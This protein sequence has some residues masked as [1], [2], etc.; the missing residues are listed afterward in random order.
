MRLI[1][2]TIDYNVPEIRNALYDFWKSTNSAIVLV[3]QNLESIAEVDRG[4]AVNEFCELV[5]STEEGRKRCV[6]SDC[7]LIKKC[8]QSNKVETHVCHAGLVDIAM[9]INYRSETVGYMLLGQMRSNTDFDQVYKKVADLNIDYNE[10]KAAYESMI[11][12]SEERVKSVLNIA[13]MLTQYVFFRNF[14]TENKNSVVIQAINYI[15]ANLEKNLS[16]DE[17]SKSLGISKSVLYRN[18]HKYLNCTVGEYVN[19]RRIDY[20]KNLFSETNKNLQ[21]ISDEVGFS[22]Y[23]YFS[24]V[25]KKIEGTTPLKYRKSL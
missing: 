14:I 23:A 5:H 25:F 6:Q 7:T 10:I 3:N 2:V 20:A 4:N 18:F 8:M 24:K 19:K 11:I 12:S 21:Q 1:C 17:I 22:S 16:I 13:E 9:P 15:S